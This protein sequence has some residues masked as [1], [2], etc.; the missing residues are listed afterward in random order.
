M[1]ADPLLPEPVRLRLR[2]DVLGEQGR[3]L[4]REAID[5]RVRA[6]EIEDEQ[7]AAR[8][9]QLDLAETKRAAGTDDVRLAED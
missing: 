5:L 2:A 6:A 4:L 8:S 1:S 3:R 7:V 9:A